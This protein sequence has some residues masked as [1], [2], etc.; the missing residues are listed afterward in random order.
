MKDKTECPAD[1]GNGFFVA[2]REGDQGANSSENFENK[3]KNNSE[4]GVLYAVDLG[5]NKSAHG[6]FGG[7]SDCSD[8]LRHVLESP[9]QDNVSGSSADENV[10]R[11]DLKYTVSRDACDGFTGK[12]S[13]CNIKYYS[14]GTPG[15]GSINTV[16]SADEDGTKVNR[17]ARKHSRIFLKTGNLMPPEI[18]QSPDRTSRG[19]SFPSRASALKALVCTAMMIIFALLETTFFSRFRIL[20]VVPDLMLHFVLALSLSLDERWCAVFGI[21]AAVIVESLGTSGL[22]FL[23]PVYMLAGY[24][25]SVLSTMYFRDSFAV[26]ALYVSAGALIRSLYTLVFILSTLGRVTFVFVFCAI[27]FPELI[28]NLVLGCIPHLLVKLSLKPFDRSTVR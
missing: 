12:K 20:G 7:D 21:A 28:A 3:F 9:V 22:S 27:I 16:N 11:N 15:S 5:T 6:S 23:V 13:P 4:S 8:T 2:S 26:R 25:G 10:P 1:D 18:A 19:F 14:H 24:A 17:N